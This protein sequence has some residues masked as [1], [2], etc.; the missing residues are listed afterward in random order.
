MRTKKTWLPRWMLIA[1]ALS[2]AG[3]C[4]SAAAFAVAIANADE[5]VLLEGL[6]HGMFEH[7][8]LETER[9]SKPVRES[10]G[11]PFYEPPLVPTADDARRLTQLLSDPAT[12]ERVFLEKKCGGFHP[13]YAVEWVRGGERYQAQICFGCGEVKLFGPGIGGRYELSDGAVAELEVMLAR[14]RKNRPASSTGPQ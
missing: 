10:H 9:R 13:D 7:E 8:L 1:L 6:P 4:S 12:L 11:H 2:L 3:G 5:V 14:Y